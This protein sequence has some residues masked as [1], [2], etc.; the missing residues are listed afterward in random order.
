MW[1]TAAPG[2]ELIQISS[3]FKGADA[4]WEKGVF[5]IQRKSDRVTCEPSSGSSVLTG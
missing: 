3:K 4:E 2:A 1:S 5:E